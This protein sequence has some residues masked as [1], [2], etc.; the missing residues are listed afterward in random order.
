MNKLLAG[1]AGVVASIAVA[2]TAVQAETINI[3]AWTNAGP[4][5]S[6]TWIRG[7]GLL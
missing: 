5:P 3:F 6:V 4:L 2:G 7:A 1:V